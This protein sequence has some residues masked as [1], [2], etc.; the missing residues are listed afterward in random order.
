MVEVD[1]TQV[2]LALGLWRGLLHFYVKILLLITLNGYNGGG[3]IIIF[4]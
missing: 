4:V 3:N 2:V 1:H